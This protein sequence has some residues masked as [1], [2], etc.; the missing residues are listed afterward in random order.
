MK[1]D[2]RN[3]YLPFKLIGLSFFLLFTT[4]SCDDIFE[5]DE[6]TISS[7]PSNSSA[8]MDFFDYGNFDEPANIIFNDFEYVSSSSGD[9]IILRNGSRTATIFLIPGN[10][11]SGSDA[12]FLVNYSDPMRDYTTDDPLNSE[13]GIRDSFIQINNN[14]YIQ[15]DVDGIFESTGSFETLEFRIN[16]TVLK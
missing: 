4:A 14:D 3:L 2:Y 7:R 16:A 1:M 6:E 11:V 10:D 5:E 12:V 15:I 13:I 9:R 8:S